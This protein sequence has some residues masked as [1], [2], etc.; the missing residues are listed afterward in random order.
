MPPALYRCKAGGMVYPASTIYQLLHII[1]SP[2]SLAIAMDDTLTSAFVFFFPYFSCP[3]GRAGE[4][5]LRR[6]AA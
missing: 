6:P 3:S 5:R 2:L 4:G 1:H